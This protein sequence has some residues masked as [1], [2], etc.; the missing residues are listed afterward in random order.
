MIV[1]FP[2][3][4]HGTPFAYSNVN[5]QLCPHELGMLGPKPVQYAFVIAEF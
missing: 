2:P 3:R 1:S 4:T 5:L